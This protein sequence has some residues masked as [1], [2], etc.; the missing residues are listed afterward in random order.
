ML[1]G[2]P[3]SRLVSF[4]DGAP[5]GAVVWVLNDVS[6]TELATGSVTPVAGS[7]ST[8]IVVPA[9]HN[10]LGVEDPLRVTR[11]LSWSYTTGGAVR[12]GAE[13][14]F[15]EGRLPFPTS[16]EGVRKLLG[17][18]AHNLPDAEIDLIGAYWTIQR[19]AGAD[20]LAALANNDGPDAM[21]IA[22]GIEAQAALVVLP[23]MPSRLAMKESSG[24][25]SYQRGDV[26][27]KDVESRLQQYIQAA[28]ALVTNEPEFETGSIFQ[29]TLPVDRFSP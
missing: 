18:P 4:N 19:I 8:H 17:S 27:W 3:Y 16:E 21:V 9:Q 22:Q 12:A 6:G 24:T 2:Q 5:D 11:D 29:L 25:D 15:V 7:I 13:R 20:N 23:T 28:V 26:D 10:T 1:S 14:Y